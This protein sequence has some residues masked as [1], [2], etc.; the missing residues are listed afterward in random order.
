VRGFTCLFQ[1]AGQPGAVFSGGQVAGAGPLA[2]GHLPH[3]TDP[4]KMLLVDGV[5]TG[6][7]ANI[8]S[9]ATTL[10]QKESCILLS[11]NITLLFQKEF[12]RR[13]SFLKF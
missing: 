1:S 2:A 4:E 5:G 8:L 11:L 10:F 9:K 3:P 12:Y 7:R 13:M 6:A